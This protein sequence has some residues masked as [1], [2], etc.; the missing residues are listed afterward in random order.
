MV[1]LNKMAKFKLICQLILAI[2]GSSAAVGFLICTLLGINCGLHTKSLDLSV[3]VTSDSI[4]DIALN[5][6]KDAFINKFEK[7]EIKPTMCFYVPLRSNE[8]PFLTLNICPL[9]NVT[10]ERQ[11]DST[12]IVL[13]S[14]DALEAIHFYSACLIGQICRS[15]GLIHDLKDAEVTHCSIR[16]DSGRFALCFSE[17]YSLSHGYIKHIY[18]N[19]SEILEFYKLLLAYF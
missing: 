19:F 16:A 1:E 8:S 13:L 15:H 5:L 9:A 10:L 2:I 12:K 14:T 18:L 11:A 7:M 4:S 6:V 3:N 17:N